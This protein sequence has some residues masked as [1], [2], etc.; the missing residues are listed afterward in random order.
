MEKYDAIVIGGGIAGVSLAYELQE[1]RSV[2][3]LEMETHLAFHTTGRSA[4]TFLETY[5][6]P[7]I[8]A[9]TTGSRDF[10][11]HPPDVFEHSPL[12]RLGLV[13]V[14]THGR[15]AKVRAMQQEMSA[16][17]PDVRL[18]SADD[19]VEVNPILRREYVE[20]ALYEPGAMELD[21]HL[22]HQGFVRGFRERG[23]VVHTAARVTGAVRSEDFDDDHVWTLTDSGGNK[24]QAPLVVNAAGSWVDVVAAMFGARSVGIAPLRRTIFMVP[25]P[26]G[27][28]TAALPM[29]AD[30]DD[31]FYVKPDGEQYLCSPAD[32]VLQS[33]SDP[34]PDELRIAQAMEVIDAATHIRPR[35]VRS[36]WAGLRNFAPDRVPVVGFDAQ[37]AGFF[38]FGGQ[39]GYGIQTAPAMARLGAALVRGEQ[40]PADLVDRGLDAARL[41]PGRFAAQ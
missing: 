5:G 26:H 17:V 8:R 29:A 40:P 34:R 38:W 21:V 1:D 18:L 11:E 10:F 3:L 39:G 19:A 33:P 9:L 20:L 23:G 7:Q 30:V 16:L 27:S 41:A 15:S 4:A 2:G 13:W 31:T 35:H 28:R 25:S 36:S 37:L 14:G 22:L 6:G 24:Y 32:E 12:R